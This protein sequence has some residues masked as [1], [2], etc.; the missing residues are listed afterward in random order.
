MALHRW[1]VC[2]PALSLHTSTL[3]GRPDTVSPV[4]TTS[5]QGFQKYP[6]SPPPPTPPHPSPHELPLPAQEPVHHRSTTKNEYAPTLDLLCGG[7]CSTPGLTSA[8]MAS[9]S[10]WQWTAM[11]DSAAS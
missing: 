6:Y 9:F 8:S 7:G 4:P 10:F 5:L 2:F 3:E 1:L 11:A